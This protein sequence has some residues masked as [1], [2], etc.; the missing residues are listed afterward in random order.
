MLWHFDF[1]LEDPKE[2]WYGKLKAFMIWERANLRVHLTP[3]E[4]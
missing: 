4:R 3:I 2:D 1:E